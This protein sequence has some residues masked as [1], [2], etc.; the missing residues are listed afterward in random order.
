MPSGSGDVPIDEIV[1]GTLL[2]RVTV[3]VDCPL[4]FLAVTVS[5]P[6][7]GI[8][9]GAVYKP[10]AVTVPETTD[11]DV[12]PAAVNCSVA[13]STRVTFVDAISGAS[14]PPP[15]LV[16]ETGTPSVLPNTEPE[17]LTVTVVD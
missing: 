2:T 16:P 1:G 7:A 9:L 10:A 12:A 5:V 3:A 8:T 4:E 11:Q 15:E 6:S 17:F 14:S 13:P